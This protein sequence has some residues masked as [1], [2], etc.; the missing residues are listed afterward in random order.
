MNHR[1]DE[2]G[3]PIAAPVRVGLLGAGRIAQSAHLPAI[4]HA[5]SVQLIGLFDPSDYLREAV[6]R[7]YEVT[8]YPTAQ[9]LLDDPSIESVIV[10]VPDRFHAAAA[11]EALGK[12]KHVLVEK[13]L[14]STVAEAEM[15]VDAS[16]RS[17]KIVQVGSMKRHDPGVRFAARVVTERIGRILSAT[18]WYRVMS[19]LRPATEATFFPPMVVDPAVRAVEAAHRP[20]RAAYLLA[21]HGAHVFDT[22]RHLCGE[23]T[24]L[25]VRHAVVGDDHAWH[26]LAS[27]AEGGLA[28]VEIAATVHAEWSEGAWI[29]GERG[30]VTVRTPF[31]VSLQA[32]VV[33][34]FD[35]ASGVAE[36]PVFGDTNP[37][38]LQVEAFARAI[39]QGTRASPDA[40]DGVA[41]V[42]LIEAAS[43]SATSGGTW[44]TP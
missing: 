42:R 17:G 19:A 11:L 39:R 44:V 10:A 5:P 1:E 16:R 43:R 41:A 30:S 9:A 27:L 18:F 31:P 4:A 13:P 7:R 32:S 29:H 25:M 6:S 35:E 21:T 34:A 8:A 23:A 37:Y 22:L 36:R 2:M 26:G 33:E 3:E 20:D 24:S 38:K 14:A 12:G 15:V 28:H 40:E